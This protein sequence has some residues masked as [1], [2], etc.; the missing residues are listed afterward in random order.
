[1]ENVCTLKIFQLILQALYN[2]T[3]KGLRGKGGCPLTLNKIKWCLAPYNS[4]NFVKCNGSQLLTH[5]PI[6]F[7]WIKSLTS[8]PHSDLNIWRFGP[9]CGLDCVTKDRR[10]KIIIPNKICFAPIRLFRSQLSSRGTTTLLYKTLIR[11]VV[12]YGAKT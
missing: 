11:P 9:P 2:K 4:K 8:S 1:V 6:C 10:K 3:T 12:A 5:H 7:L